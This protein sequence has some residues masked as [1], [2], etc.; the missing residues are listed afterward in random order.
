MTKKQY[1]RYRAE[2][3]LHALKRAIYFVGIRDPLIPS[4]YKKC[5][6]ILI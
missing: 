4:G 3:K 5:S 6:L 1:Q 2:F